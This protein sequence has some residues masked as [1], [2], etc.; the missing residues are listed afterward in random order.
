MTASVHFLRTIF[1]VADGN[2][3]NR[4]RGRDQSQ[5]RNRVRTQ[6]PPPAYHDLPPARQNHPP[7]DPRDNYQNHSRPYRPAHDYPG[8]QYQPYN[9]PGSHY[10]HPGNSG[11]YHPG[12]P[13]HYA[14]G[15]SPLPGPDYRNYN[16]NAYDPRYDGRGKYQF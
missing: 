15:D 6:S 4:Q 8:P 2:Q 3:R 1:L 11:S 7:Y 9:Y 5:T 10:R 16:R 14:Y 12:Y 13:A